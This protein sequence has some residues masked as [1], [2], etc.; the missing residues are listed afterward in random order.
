M[1][2]NWS[3]RKVVWLIAGMGLGLALATYWPHEPLAYGQTAVSGDEFAMCTVQTGAGDADAIFILDFATGRLQGAVFNNKVNAFSQ[4]MV[5]NI[6]ADFGLT[7]R[8]DYVMVT[9]FVGARSRGGQPAS[10]GVYVA[11]LTTGQVVLYGFINI[12]QGTR[13]P[14]ELSVLGTFPWRAASN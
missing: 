5:R 8:G 10:G 4:P 1:S 12:T 2:R 14:Q 13:V 11:E 9:G 6:A 3:D 7:E